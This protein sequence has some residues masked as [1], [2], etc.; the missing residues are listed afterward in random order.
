MVVC[1]LWVP[2]SGVVFKVTGQLIHFASMG[3]NNNNNK[4]VMN[5]YVG[6]IMKVTLTMERSFQICVFFDQSENTLIGRVSFI[7]LLP[8][9]T[10]HRSLL[11]VYVFNFLPNSPSGPPWNEG[12][13][14]KVH[15]EISVF[16]VQVQEQHEHS[17]YSS[18]T[19]T[20]ITG[21]L[22]TVRECRTSPGAPDLWARLG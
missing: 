2:F 9:V 17:F 22:Y 1:N 12:H 8:N 18:S 10:E 15:H 11:V 13:Q 16:E 20:F 4:L 6:L 7:L 3:Q 21:S 14:P 5:I 19:S